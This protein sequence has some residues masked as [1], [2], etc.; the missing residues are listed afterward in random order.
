MDGADIF[1]LIPDMIQVNFKV[2]QMKKDF[3]FNIRKNEKV[4]KV[5]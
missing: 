4:L 2:P 5:I 3:T 1:D